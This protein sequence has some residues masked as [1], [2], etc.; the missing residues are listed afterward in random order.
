MEC[1]DGVVETPILLWRQYFLTCGELDIDFYF[2]L[3]Y[4]KKRISKEIE[5]HM[6]QNRTFTF[7]MLLLI[8]LGLS[9]CSSQTKDNSLN[10]TFSEYYQNADDYEKIYPLLNEYFSCIQS[11]YDKS[12]KS[13]L[14]SFVLP[15]EYTN[16][17]SQL[18]EISND[19]SGFIV[20]GKTNLSKEYLA[21]LQLLEPYLE[22]EYFIKQKDLLSVGN[23]NSKIALNDEWFNEVDA[24]LTATYSK[25]EN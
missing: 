20:D 23:G 24:F 7:I 11:A 9:A 6:K 4:N 18:S 14:E 3:Q 10:I 22:M 15:D 12:D 21:R 2:V 1:R 19:N 17:S 5:N 25:Y 13:D 8:V 16:V